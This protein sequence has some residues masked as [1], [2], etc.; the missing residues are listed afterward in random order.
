MRSMQWQLGILGTISAFAYRHR[1][2]KKNLCRGD[3]SQD[4]PNTDLLPSSPASKV[5]T[6][7][8]SQYRKYTILG[9]LHLILLIK[10]SVFSSFRNFSFTV[11]FLTEKK[12]NLSLQIRRHDKQRFKPTSLCLCINTCRI[13]IVRWCSDSEEGHG[14]LHTQNT[15]TLIDRWYSSPCCVNV[16]YSLPTLEVPSVLVLA[17]LMYTYAQ[18]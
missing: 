9:L 15:N 10:F 2:T 3:R 6:A 16:V 4:L 7:V 18:H 1:E 12:P 5:K 14:H 8:H 13:S 17:V 11:F